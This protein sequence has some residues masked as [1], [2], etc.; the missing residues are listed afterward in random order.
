MLHLRVELHAPYAL[1][2]IL[3]S[4][5][6]YAVGRCRNVIALRNGCYRIAVA[7]PHLRTLVKSLEQ[8]AVG[9]NES[10]IGTTVF[11]CTG[12]FNLTAID[13]AEQLCTVADSKYGI[14]AYNARQV[15]TECVI[16]IHAKRRSTQNHTYNV[17]IIFWETDIRE[18]L[19]ERIQFSYS[20]AYQ[21]SGLRAKIKNNDLLHK[22]FYVFRAQNYTKRAKG[23]GSVWLVL[24]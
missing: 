18:N 8:R 11:T 19:A 2:S 3:E 1:I 12:L 9:S 10:Q 6:L 4:G 15:R 23:D 7:H 24:T 21:L 17:R 20:T 13:I 22:G 14:L 5:K 16:G